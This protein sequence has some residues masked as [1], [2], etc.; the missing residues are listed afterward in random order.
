MEPCATTTILDAHRF[1]MSDVTKAA[2]PVDM[3]NG[4]AQ[5]SF[6]TT[7]AILALPSLSISSA[8]M[9]G[10][11]L[12]LASSLLRSF[13][14]AINILELLIAYLALRSGES[15]RHGVAQTVHDLTMHVLLSRWLVWEV[16]IAGVR[17]G[18]TRRDR[19]DQPRRGYCGMKLSHVPSHLRT[20]WVV[21]II[22][23]R[24][25]SG[26]QRLKQLRNDWIM[27]TSLVV[28]VA[29]RNCCVKHRC[30]S[31]RSKGELE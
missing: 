31:G 18:W 9:L 10:L 23:V 15:T 7:L 25:K 29:H 28:I 20:M 2:H 22:V 3:S 24:G 5:N 13:L 1:I 11:P 12:K 4:R 14:V 19:L 16:S 27:N 26:W 8:T 6:C 21:S 30:S 17:W